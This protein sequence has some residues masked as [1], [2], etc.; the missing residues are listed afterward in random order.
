MPSSDNG[1]VP[2]FT[3]DALVQDTHPAGAIPGAAAADASRARAG[4]GTAIL[5]ILVG[6]LSVTFFFR[7]E[8]LDGF[9]VLR[10]NR[11]DEVI[12][13]SIYEHWFSVFRAMAHWNRTEYFYPF[14][15]TLGYND[16]FFLYGVIYSSF[17][18]AHLDP[19][20]SGECVSIVVRLIGF[21]GFFW[22]AR[23]V[24]GLRSGWALFGAVLFTLSNNMFVQAHHSQL[25]G[26]GFAPVMAVLLDGM[27]A[28]LLLGRTTPFLLWGISAALLYPAWLLTTYYM[29]W[30]FCLFGLF[31]GVAYAILAGRRGLVPWWNAVR[32][33]AAQS[34]II[35]LVL[36][37]SSIPFLSVYLPT[38]S[39]TGMHPYQGVRGWTLTLPDLMHVG[40]GNLL[41]GRIVAF[42]N[43]AIRPTMPAWSERMTG[44]PPGLLWLFGWGAIALLVTRRALV[45]GRATMLRALAIATLATWALAFNVDGHSLWW[46]MYEAFPGAKAARVVA[47][48]QLF[49]AVPV[50]GIA[51]LYL[52]ASARKVA[53]PVLILVCGLL[54]VE[55]INTAAGVSLD[56]A[57][58]LARLQAVPAPPP[59]CKAFFVS[60]ARPEGL[61]G[62]AW[63]GFF[64]HNVD[65]MIIAE[66]LHLP[67]INGASTFQPPGWQ[68]KD[69]DKPDYL[70]RVRRYAMASHVTQLCSIDLTTMQWGHFPLASGS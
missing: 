25:L 60:R 41:Y 9:T 47:R 38:A 18:T 29:A 53:A 15:G 42:V 67:T 62:P 48:Y 5:V 16:G 3:A 45:P 17:R 23:R 31:M 57:H 65:A 56:R 20:L 36:C 63:D 55:E 13:I 33:H 44:F 26:V 37:A 28:A 50:T 69:S 24:L 70:D 66:T 7:Y 22:A 34:A 64:S 12:I 52:S 59:D 21:L 27:M 14:K 61:L 10:G 49:L 46:F 11:Y 68:L 6:L 35:L 1:V 8:I 40:D 4:V 19:Y 32:R 39:E 43:H 54:V 2:T 30:Y 51:V 58:E